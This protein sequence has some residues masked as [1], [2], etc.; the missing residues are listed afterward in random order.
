MTGLDS[1]CVLSKQ[2]RITLGRCL[3]AITS[4]EHLAG[5]LQK[6]AFP[7]SSGRG[8]RKPNS[9]KTPKRGLRRSTLGNPTHP[10]HPREESAKRLTQHMA[11]SRRAAN[12]L[13]MNRTLGAKRRPVLCSSHWHP[14]YACRSAL[15]VPIA[16]GN[17]TRDSPGFCYRR[18][19]HVQP[20]QLSLFSSF[21]PFSA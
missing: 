2:D 5:A 21:R 12:R 14:R 8:F 18:W 3:P 15:Q 17:V 16:N 10:H 13:E 4:Q 1:H 20:R 7:R 11:E 6:K 9:P 19:N